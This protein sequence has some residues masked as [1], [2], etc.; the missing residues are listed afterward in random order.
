MKMI[1]LTELK[2]TVLNLFDSISH[3]QRKVK[4]YEE[5]IKKLEEEK[6][7]LLF[8]LKSEVDLNKIIRHKLDHCQDQ[9]EFWADL[10]IK[11]RIKND[12]L[13]IDIDDLH[14][15]S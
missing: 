12:K 7:D 8:R 11:Q 10:A 15:K 5:R 3:E 2:Q 1:N 9:K 14:L 13:E 6:I 4:E